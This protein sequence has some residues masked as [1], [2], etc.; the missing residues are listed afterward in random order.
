MVEFVVGLFAILAAAVAVLAVA[1]LSR[2]D[3]DAMA[4]AQE[5]AVE[6]SMGNGVSSDFP[7]PASPCSTGA[8]K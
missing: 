4:E 8:R 6:A 2:A 3:T 7:I 5:R 1:E